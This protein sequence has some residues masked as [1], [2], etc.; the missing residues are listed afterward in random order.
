MTLSNINNWNQSRI[1]WL[2]AM[3]SI[4]AFFIIEIFPLHVAQW[5]LAIVGIVFSI[6]FFVFFN[7]STSGSGVGRR[8]LAAKHLVNNNNNNNGVGGP[9]TAA[10][11]AAA[12]VNGNVINHN[13]NN[14]SNDSRNDGCPSYAKGDEKFQEVID[15]M[16]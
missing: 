15:N 13:E 3:A 6:L 10:A 8:L 12:V 16:S 1:Y 7:K 14:S 2:V 9:M 11:A 5:L 4:I